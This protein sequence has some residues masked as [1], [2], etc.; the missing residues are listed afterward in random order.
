MD[1]RQVSDQER[2]KTLILINV[3]YRR[4]CL[5]LGGVQIHCITQKLRHDE[6][7]DML[8][9]TC[10]GV[11]LGYLFQM[12]SVGFYPSKREASKIFFFY[13]AKTMSYSDVSSK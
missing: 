11:L 12:A 1:A 7:Y 8:K 5:A 4:F 13:V 3:F 2:G 10:T 9:C 6:S